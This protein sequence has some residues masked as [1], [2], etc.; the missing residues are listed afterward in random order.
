MK[1]LTRHR[2]LTLA[3]DL[4]ETAINED[5]DFGWSAA[6]VRAGYSADDVMD[7]LEEMRKKA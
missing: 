6:D 3:I 1:T 7:A 5:W 4:I 2:A